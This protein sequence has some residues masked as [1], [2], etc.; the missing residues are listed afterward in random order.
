MARFYRGTKDAISDALQLF[1]KAI[2][3][4]PEFASAYGM[5][6]LCYVTRKSHLWMAERAQETAAMGRLARQAARLGKDDPT[7]LYAGGFALAQVEGHLDA[8]AALIDRALALDPNLAATWHTSGWV[9]IHLREPEAAIEH[10]TR[11]MRLNPVDP[12]P[13]MMQHGMA[14]AY[15][16]A[17]RYEEASSWAEKALREH[18]NYLPAIRMSA[19][20]LAFAGRLTEA[21]KAMARMREIDPALRAAGLKDLVPFR[22]PDDF[23]RY[24]EGLRRAELPD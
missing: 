1:N 17:G 10:L 11:A 8:G 23:A 12:Q 14:A 18:P 7:A 3:L 19:A 16:L 20:S 13:Y 5:A 15:F 2:A 24:V 4:D 21:Q 22:R 6:A 9:R